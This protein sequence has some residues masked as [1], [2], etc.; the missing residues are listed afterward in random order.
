MTPHSATTGEIL[1]EGAVANISKKQEQVTSECFMFW[2][3][4]INMPAA[5]ERMRELSYTTP[6]M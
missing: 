3:L 5:G 4:T 6:E 1:F 2:V